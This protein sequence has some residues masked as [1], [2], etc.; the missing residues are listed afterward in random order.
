MKISTIKIKAYRTIKDEIIIDASSG[1]TLV[2]PNN[3]GKTNILKAI[4]LFFTGYDSRFEYNRFA[5]LPFSQSSV[6]TN[7][8][9][10]FLFESPKDNDVIELLIELASLLEIESVNMSSITVYLTF[11]STSNPVYRVFPNLKRPV[12]PTQKSAYSRTERKLIEK[13]ISRFKVHYIPS[14]KSTEQLYNDIILPFLIKEAH[15]AIGPQLANISSSL[16]F[17]SK[18]VSEGLGKAGITNITCHFEL[19]S[20]PI[21]VFKNIN[22]LLKDPSSTS[23][24]NKG[25]GIQSAALIAA[26]KWIT[27]QHVR[28]GFEVI[29]L[30]EEPESYLHPELASQ[31]NSLLDD[32]RQSAQVVST[33]HSLA[34]VPQDPSRIT[35]VI[36]TG[37]WTSTQT[38]STYHQATYRIRNALGLKFA[39]FYNLAKYNV[40]VEGETDREYLNFMQIRF[41]NPD[42]VGQFP[43]FLSNDIAFLDFGGV[44]GLSGFV[45]AT[46]EFIRQ[47]RASVILFDG[48]GAGEKHRRDLI[49][50]FGQKKIG[51]NSNQEYI[52]VKD[53]FSIEGLFPDDWIKEC[54]SEHAGW[55]DDFSTDALGAMLPFTIN[56]RS[57]R[58]YM[59]YMINRASNSD[60]DTWAVQWIKLI[61]VI[62][63]ALCDTHNRLLQL[64]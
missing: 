22:F 15:S 56:D 29:W 28:N 1:T 10:T 9:F 13:I 11:S 5:D 33:T 36:G 21:D 18:S 49:G 37:G 2:G 61:G 52:I 45:R 7:L 59:E 19:P 25:M 55:F 3:A 57:K 51:F 46:Y 17:I 35:G 34:F 50:Y 27:E 41:R 23:I 32:L 48:D 8:S 20:D 6:Q 12:N 40:L 54:S 42:Y 4:R 58:K 62:E 26:F 60:D 39:D 30:V 43:I 44:S 38:F 53:R 63:K 16:D 24:F 31:C 64:V 47:E 14:D